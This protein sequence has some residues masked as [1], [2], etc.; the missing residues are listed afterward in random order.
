MSRSATRRFA[1]TSSVALLG[2]LAC[3]ALA[4]PAHA[5]EL[6]TLLGKPLRLEVTETSIVAQRFQAREGELPAD[7]GYFAWLNRLNMS[8]DWDHFQVA[9]RLDSSVYAFRPEDR[10]YDDPNVERNVRVD[11]ATRYRDALYPA[12]LWAS[13]KNAGIEVTAGDAYVQLGRGLVLSMRKVDELG[14]DTTLFG[15]KVAI[16]KDPIAVT[17]VAG[18]A[19]P[20]RVD[21]PTGRALFLSKEV[22]GQLPRT[23][24]FGSDRI[25]GAQIQA[26]RGLGVVLSTNVAQLTKCAPYRYD[27]AGNVIA[28]SFDAP[29]GSCDERDRGLWIDSLP[30]GL[31]PVVPARSV[32][33]AS[34]SLEIPKLFSLGTLYV[35]GAV[36]HRDVDAVVDADK[37]GNAL[38][39]SLS[40]SGQVLT[41]TI[42]AKS[43][44]NYYPL[45]GSVNAGRAGAFANVVYSNPPT[46]EVIIQDSMFGFFNTC[47]DGA[48]DRLDVRLTKTLLVYGA[49]GVY[50]SR[51]ELPGATGCDRFGRTRSGEADDSR[52]YVTDLNPGIEWRFDDDKS[53]LFANVTVRNDVTAASERFYRE[54][55][56]QYSLTKH[57]KGPY[58]VELSGRHRW[59]SQEDENLRGED[60]EPRPWVQG[61]HQTALKIAPKWVISQG[62]E[63]TSFLGFPSTYVNGGVLYRFTPES[64]LRL[65]GGQNRG[66]LRCVSGVCRVFPAFSGVR[67]ELTIRF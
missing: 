48:R 61:E 35:E 30:K 43:Y 36:Q 51:A 18:F 1:Q 2:A 4:A 28:S 59:R 26:G 47:V 20:S 9:T 22:P 62:V 63:Y 7:Q 29:F 24:V 12:K 31:G 57:V 17:L 6:P 33:N 58:S 39:G 67:A 27:D 37:Q 54:R 66:G 41:N 50:Q 52:T 64:N 46:A 25:V 19:N 13:Y 21:E 42:E 44:R 56:I 65:Y 8:L 34:Q 60:A 11:G 38:Y 45:A 53:T 55:A 23:P 16:Q 10:T 15:G 32:L 49:L 40:T 3:A 14:V 5:L